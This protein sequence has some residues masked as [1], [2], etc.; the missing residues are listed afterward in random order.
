MSSPAAITTA[1]PEHTTSGATPP[2]GTDHPSAIATKRCRQGRSEREEINELAGEGVRRKPHDHRGP[3]VPS[4][5]PRD[6]RRQQHRET[7]MGG[8]DGTSLP[9]RGSEIIGDR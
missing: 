4:P 9:Q 7:G 5:P 8:D 6:Q 1:R 3:V 2:I